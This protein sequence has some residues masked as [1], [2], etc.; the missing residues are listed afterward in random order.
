MEG[1]QAAEEPKSQRPSRKSK[2]LAMQGLQNMTAKKKK[3]KEQVDK[4]DGSED[5]LM[6]YKNKIQSIEMMGNKN[7]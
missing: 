1:D 4:E 2:V 5:R 6:S 3:E 7:I